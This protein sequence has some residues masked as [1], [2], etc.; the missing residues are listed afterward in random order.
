MSALV[1]EF[2]RA[3]ADTGII[4]DAII[5]ADKKIHRFRVEGD[6]QGSRNGWYVLHDDGVPAGAFR[7]WKSDER[8][9]WCAK[10]WKELTPAEHEAHRCSIEAARHAREAGEKQ[11]YAEAAVE[12]EHLWSEAQPE[13]GEH[14]YLQNKGVMAHGIRTN[15]VELLIPLHDASGK[16]HSLQRIRPDGTKRFLL[17]GAVT[18]NYHE[19][20]K[21]DGR[22]IICEG[23]ATAASIH[24]ATE[25]AVAVA[26]NAVNL[27]PVARAL[28]AKFPSIDIVVAAD[29]DAGTVGNPGLTKA[30]AAAKAVGGSLAIPDFGDDRPEDMT[31][32]NDLAHLRGPEAVRRCI[33]IDAVSADVGPDDS[34]TEDAIAL[35]FARR[36]GEE[37]RWVQEWS[38]W[39]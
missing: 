35:E 10:S 32:F 36:Y 6:K 5:I 26:F 14:C 30:T 9:T 37:L 39:L 38:R 13:T 17:E 29:D 4:T 23:Y 12:A 31:D 28:R 11:S 27:E 3:M 18:G 22:L 7:W 8:H 1:E 15:G 34:H 21:P 2:R 20:G 19:I 33:D 25:H 16:L 24:E